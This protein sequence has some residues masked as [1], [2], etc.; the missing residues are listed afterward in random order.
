VGRNEGG[1]GGDRN[2]PNQTIYPRGIIGNDSR[3]GFRLSGS[4][5]TWGGI[6]VAG[7]FVSNQGYPYVSSYNLTRAVAAQQGIT[8]TRS[9]QN[10]TLSQRGDE[11]LPNVTLADIRI[12]RAFRMGNRQFVPTLDIF[13][14][15]NVDTIV[16]LNNSVGGTYLEPREI[17]A[18]RIIRLGF[19]IDF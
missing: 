15:S 4:Y 13:N 5:Q 1:L 3:F 8:L 6:V 12:S 16:S 9:S 7:S 14:I 11:R 18:P 19:S 17:I 10:I 2:D